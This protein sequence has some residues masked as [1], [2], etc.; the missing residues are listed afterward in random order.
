MDNIEEWLEELKKADKLIIVEG[1]KD[2]QLL[3]KQGLTNIMT[4]S[5]TPHF[6][7]EEIQEKEVIILTDLDAQGRKLFS[8]LKHHLQKRGVKI[9]N[10]FRD[11][12]FQTNVSHIEGIKFI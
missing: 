3:E 1:K 9:D 11:F 4:F 8:I 2:K 7:I 5:N 6:K 12:L 10:R